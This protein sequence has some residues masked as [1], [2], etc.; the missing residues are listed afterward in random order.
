MKRLF[1]IAIQMI[2]AMGVIALGMS[3][4]PGGNTPSFGFILIVLGGWWFITVT[5]KRESE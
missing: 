2:G 5:D 4:I 1:S 3:F